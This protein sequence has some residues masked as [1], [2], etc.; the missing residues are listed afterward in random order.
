MHVLP[1][2]RS[3]A[4]LASVVLILTGACQRTEPGKIPG[5]TS[6]VRGTGGTGGS[7]T[8]PSTGGAGGTATAGTGGA[9]TPGSN[10]GN[11]AGG[12]T[13]GAGGSPSDAQGAGGATDTE[14]QGGA[15][16]GGGSP[17]DAEVDTAPVDTAPVDTAPVCPGACPVSN[18][19]CAGN[20]VEECKQASENECPKWVAG[21]PCAAPLVCM[22][23]G[24]NA[25]CG[26]PSGSCSVD[27]RRCMGDGTV[28]I[29][30]NVPGACPDWQTMTTCAANKTCTDPA[31]APA[32]CRCKPVCTLGQK[33][34]AGNVI[35]E[36]V[37]EAGCP[38][39]KPGTTCQTGQTCVAAGN[40]ASCQCPGS[41]NACPALGKRCQGESVQECKAT[42]GSPACLSWQHAKAC[43]GNLVCAAGPAANVADCKCKETCPVNDQ[44]CQ[45]P[46][47]RQVCQDVAGCGVWTDMACGAGKVCEQ[48][49]PKTTSCKCATGA[50]SCMDGESRC[51]GTKY[52]VCE[53]VAGCGTFKD[54]TC[55]AGTACKQTMTSPRRIAECAPT[56]P[57]TACTV[58]SKVCGSDNKMQEC[59]LEAGCGKYFPGGCPGDNSCY[60]VGSAPLCGKPPCTDPL[61]CDAEN[62]TR[63]APPAGGTQ[64][65]QKCEKSTNPVCPLLWKTSETCSLATQ[66]CEV[67]GT[68]P[69]CCAQP[70]CTAAVCVQAAGDTRGVLT[71]C[72][73]DGRGCSIADA[74][75][76][77]ANGCND[78][79]NACK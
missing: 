30:R 57:T 2:C 35:E 9:V 61:K 73:N 77:C 32:D 71:R 55:G 1:R 68:G 65:A 33:K 23:S 10:G 7:T 4:L 58:G 53:F 37:N 66:K 14:S 70:A 75:V 34:C 17:T 3:A 36:C 8:K 64:L 29:C 74:P 67:K 40:S 47:K 79:R 49:T 26:C 56:C 16:G 22:G 6:P 41:A 12:A 39:W 62:T 43:A 54:A 18:K 69:V 50:E 27:A 76:I 13:A 28:Q 5:S 63:C 52:Q 21:T 78:A 15:G 60:K 72:K 46:A 51:V 19:R 59:R 11:G 38:I 42:P 48:S 44:R 45:G 24:K 31:N 25:G 20:V